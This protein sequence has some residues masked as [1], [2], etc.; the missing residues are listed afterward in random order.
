M[1]FLAE[2]GTEEA[3]AMLLKRFRSRITSEIA[4]RDEKEHILKIITD[5]GAKSLGPVRE[6]L[7]RED[8]IRFPLMALTELAPAEECIATAVS[9]LE[10]IGMPTPRQ[11]AKAMQLLQFL[12]EYQDPRIA[13]VAL[14]LLQE[15]TYD[16]L[17]V[18]AA[19]VLGRQPETDEIRNALLGALVNEEESQRLRNAVIDIL[20]E[21]GWG[22]QG[23]RKKV[24]AL[25]P[26]GYVVDRAGAIRKR[27]T[28]PD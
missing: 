10:G 13:K 22:V 15:E 8:E 20:A 6:F 18:V 5:A 11:R 3:L 21:N 4:D 12:E 16:D 24:E 19:T 23:Y 14:P 25:L 27:S 9:L 28:S 26:E 17:R 7:R 1:D 2:L